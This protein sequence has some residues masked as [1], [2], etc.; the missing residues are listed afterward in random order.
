M[1]GLALLV[2]SLLKLS[3][4][5]QKSLGGGFALDACSVEILTIHDSCST[6]PCQSLCRLGCG[7]LGTLFR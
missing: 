7:L 2:Q 6:F 4:T 3:D 5:H 1:C